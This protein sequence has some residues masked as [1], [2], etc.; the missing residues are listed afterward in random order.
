MREEI[1]KLLMKYT[2]LEI[3]NE[4]SVLPTIHFD[5]VA[6]EIIDYFKNLGEGEAGTGYTLLDAVASQDLKCCGNCIHRDYIDNKCNLPHQTWYDSFQVCEDW[7]HDNLL[8]NNRL[9]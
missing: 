4:R 9:G 6:D 7:K 3:D 2:E 8:F 1:T 5:K